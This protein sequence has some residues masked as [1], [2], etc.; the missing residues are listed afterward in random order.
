MHTPT[1]AKQKAAG[2]ES[3][4]VDA[5]TKSAALTGLTVFNVQLNR[6]NFDSVC[7]LH[8]DRSHKCAAHIHCCCC[9]HPCGV[10]STAC[11]AVVT[12]TLHKGMNQQHGCTTAVQPAC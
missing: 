2:P 12:T 11:Q 6:Y 4:H 7:A 5:Y 3:K 1:R 8:S 10:A 9:C